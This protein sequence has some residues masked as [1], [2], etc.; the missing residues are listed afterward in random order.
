MILK[1][2]KP[3]KKIFSYLPVILGVVVVS[4]AILMTGGLM[5]SPPAEGG[6]VPPVTAPTTTLEPSTTAFSEMSSAYIPPFPVYSSARSPKTLATTTTTTTT[7]SSTQE[8]EAGSGFSRQY[9]SIRVFLDKQ[10]IVFY[11]INPA[12]GEEYPAYAVKCS[13]GTSRYPT[14]TT[15]PN[16]PIILGGHK[17]Q[18]TIFNSTKSTELCWVRYATHLR[19]SIWFHSVPYDYLED[20]QGKPLFDPARCYMWYGYDV[21]GSMPSS[22]GCIRLALRDAMFLYY[23]TYGGMRCYVLS[24]SSGFDLPAPQ[25]LPPAL[26]GPRNW[27]PTDPGWKSYVPTPTTTP[28]APVTTTTTEVTTTIPPT[29]TTAPPVTTLPSSPPVTTEPV[30]TVT[31]PVET[32]LPTSSEP[33]DPDD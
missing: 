16:N 31:E 13:T 28:T 3:L 25:P 19:G 27:D 33:T 8:W 2:D 26:R 11:K 14:P 29:T 32:T 15:G 18:L 24:S 7:T 17:T 1:G 12:T 4:A 10:R 6:T 22:H 30:T 9:S 23:N 5:A 21:L 20:A